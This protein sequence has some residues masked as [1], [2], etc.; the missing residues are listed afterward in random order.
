[1]ECHGAARC[2]RRRHERLR[3]PCRGARAR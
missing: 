3:W 2:C 1:M